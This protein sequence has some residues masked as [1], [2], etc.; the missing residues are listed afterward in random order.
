MAHF[1]MS[2]IYNCAIAN[3]KSVPFCLSPIFHKFF[4]WVIKTRNDYIILLFFPINI[5][6]LSKD[7]FNLRGKEL[8]IVF[9]ESS[10]LE[11]LKTQLYYFCGKNTVCLLFANEFLNWK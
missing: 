6:K 11:T 8:S 9:V 4:S 5:S 10:P 1:N 2:M 3:N 7:L